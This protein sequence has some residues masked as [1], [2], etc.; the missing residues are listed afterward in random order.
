MLEMQIRMEESIVANRVKT[1]TVNESRGPLQ[2]DFLTQVFL[3][4]NV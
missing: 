3:F 1:E 4:L 2:G